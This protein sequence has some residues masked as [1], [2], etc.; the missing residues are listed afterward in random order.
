MVRYSME[1]YSSTEKVKY[2]HLHTV[3]TF[4][5]LCFSE[6]KQKNPTSTLGKWHDQDYWA[7]ILLEIPVWLLHVG[8]QQERKQPFFSSSPPK[9]SGSQTSILIIHSGFPRAALLGDILLTQ[10]EFEEATY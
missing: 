2:C 4:N 10:K 5:V 9:L 6:N 8:E 1:Y 3:T 7:K